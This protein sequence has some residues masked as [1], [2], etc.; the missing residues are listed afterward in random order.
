[1][2]VLIACVGAVL[3]GI[4]ALQLWRVHE[5]NIE[6]SDVVSSNTA[7]SI[8]EQ[9]ETNLQTADTIVASLVTQVEA[10]GTGPEALMRF[11]RLMTSLAEALP[12]IH[13]MGIVDSQGNAIATS[14]SDPSGLN[15]AERGYFRYHATNP[16][17]GPFISARIKTGIDGYDSIILT[18]RINNLD[19][20][21]A[22]I[23]VANVSLDFFQHLFDRMQAKSGGVISLI[24]DDEALLARSP[25]VQPRANENE[26]SSPLRQRMRDD[27]TASSLFYVSSVDGVW[28]RGSYQ[29]LSRFPVTALVSQSEWDV[30]NSW[31]AELRSHAIVLM[32][33]TIVL[34]VLGRSALKASRKLAAQ[35][36]QDDLTG[37]ANRRSFDETIELEVRR[38]ARSG[39]PL[40][41]M[42]IEI[43]RFKAYKDCHGG[44]AA[45]EC[46]RVV[47]HTI[48]GCLRRAG[49]FAARYRDEELAVV[50]PGADGPGA[51]A[52]AD[53]MRLAVRGLALQQARHLDGVV[54]ISAGM[55]T[56]VPGQIIGEAQA[57]VRVAEAALNAAKAAGQDRV[58][59]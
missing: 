33:V 52:L 9:V 53:I 40:S 47:A 32:R 2:L 51:C 39:Q 29:H 49:E 58:V 4:E 44:G 38:A 43:D 55:A 36:T 5:T 28:Q 11:H 26:E 1:M 50:I 27:P 14:L 54:T 3:M 16:D 37:L 10:E 48:Q 19:G 31:R 21:F 57:L 24:A 17:H 23:A 56:F 59:S 25:P 46:L 13:E 12:A 34:M 30:Q 20:S 22:G 45:D 7:R 8:A 6:Q 35:T 18:H 41:V 42:M 15:Y